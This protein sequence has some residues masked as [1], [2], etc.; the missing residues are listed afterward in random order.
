MDSVVPPAPMQN[1][2]KKTS[3]KTYR[4]EIRPGQTIDLFIVFSFGLILLVGW[5]VQRYAAAGQMVSADILAASALIILGNIFLYPRKPRWAL[6]GLQGMLFLLVA[7][8][9]LSSGIGNNGWFWLIPY[10]FITFFLQGNKQAQRWNFGMAI[11]VTV[12]TIAHG[13][14]L[15]TLPYPTE[16][17]FTYV[18]LYY[19]MLALAFL[20]NL[21]A[22]HQVH[23]IGNEMKHELQIGQELEKFKLAV[24]QVSEQIV[25]TDPDGIIIYANAATESMTGYP[26]AEIIGKK[27]GAKELWGGQMEQAFN[28]QLWQRIKKE[29][30]TFVGEIRN[31]RKDGRQYDS[32]ATISPILDEKRNILYYVSIEKDISDEKKL[33]GVLARDEAILF[34]VGDGLIATDKEGK[35][36]VVNR[37]AEWILGKSLKSLMGKSFVESIPA[38]DINHQLIPA[39]KRLVTGFITGKLP[40]AIPP[41]IKQ[42]YQRTDGVWFPI[43]TTVGPIIVGD[44][45]IGVVSVFH[46]ISREEA[47]EKTKTEFISVASHQLQTPL[48]AIGWLTELLQD[49]IAGRMTARQKDVVGKIETSNQRMVE[50]VNSLLNS[51]RAELGTFII[52]PEMTDIVSLVRDTVAEAK[53]NPPHRV[54]I[55]EDYSPNFPTIPLDPVLFRMII[56]NL[57]SNALR[58][59]PNDGRVTVRLTHDQ[60]AMTLEVSD[61]GIGIPP[62]SQELIYLK[63]YRAANAARMQPQ[64]IG[65]GMYLVKSI[66]DAAGGQI[67]FTSIEN[68]G[69]TFQ[70]SFPLSGM[71]E[72]TGLRHLTLSQ[73][74]KPTLT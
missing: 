54:T 33:E 27:A 67:T 24:D 41:R 14:D 32:Q 1:R 71:K 49:N 65:L 36:T 50:I 52:T 45:L 43:V 72:K 44:E 16:I 25:I 69:T 22:Q 18:V 68:K 51:S 6:L 61:T 29:K 34:N 17:V 66:V 39:E 62:G 23:V 31:K 7:G 20:V 60:Q 40:T 8:F 47:I 59:T 55:L 35:I 28:D 19:F 38:Q 73:T 42:Y 46:D 56:Q 12:V 53:V 63:F 21:Q 2:S 15:I 58:Y 74:D 37:A 26:M 13:L 11:F 57:L 64:G 30:K 3:E 4:V 9:F 5:L 48:S 70:V 10:S